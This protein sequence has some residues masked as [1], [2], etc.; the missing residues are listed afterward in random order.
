MRKCRQCRA[1]LPPK[2]QCPDPYMVAGFCSKDHAIEH[3][4]QLA[5][6]A[7]E[8]QK[9]A[10]RRERREAEK[11]R[12]AKHR[13]DKERIKPTSK[14]KREAQDAFNAFIRYRDRDQMCISC[15]RSI[16]EIEGNDGWKPGGCWDCGHYLT[17]GGF[18]ELR[19]VEIN[20]HRQCK[21]CNAGA[22]K[23]ARKNQTVGEIYRKKLIERIGLNQVEW[24]E[25]PHEPKRYR[26]DD[27]RRIRDEYRAKL[28]ELKK[29]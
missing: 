14:L 2:K 7:L 16:Q 10:E 4:T 20:A 21:S 28:R 26:A 8:K 19:F 15:D 5:L 11:Q 3:K 17:V 1:E 18:E 6:K 22:G 25:G 13:E 27:F 12:R 29:A 9:S 24:L 23:Y